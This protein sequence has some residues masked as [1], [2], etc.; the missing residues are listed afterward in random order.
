MNVRVFFNDAAGGSFA[1]GSEHGVAS[2]LRRERAYAGGRPYMPMMDGYDARRA[3]LVE[4]SVGLMVMP[5]A[6]DEADERVAERVFAM[7]NADDR[8]NGRVERSLSVGDVVQVGDHRYAVDNV[9]F[10]CVDAEDEAAH[11]DAVEA[12]I[13]AEEVRIAEDDRDDRPGLSQMDV[14]RD[15][16]RAMGERQ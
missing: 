14:E 12:A 4:S 2:D 1:P 8:P 13:G 7:L 3:V 5:Q 11:E 16:Y 10:R 15:W 6:A 9:G